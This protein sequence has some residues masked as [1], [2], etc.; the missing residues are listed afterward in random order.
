MAS[1]IST[2]VGHQE[3]ST[4][5]ISRNVQEAAT[6]TASVS[7]AVAYVKDTAETTDSEARDISA[8]ASSLAKRA[9]DLEVQVN[10]FIAKIKGQAA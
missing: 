10:G 7:E 1:S 3:V 9:D 4:M 2:A 8:A 5:E 6:G